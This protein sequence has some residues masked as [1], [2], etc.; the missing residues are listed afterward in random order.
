M[1]KLLASLAFLTLLGFVSC[2]EYAEDKTSREVAVTMNT[3]LNSFTGGNSV[4]FVGNTYSL[5]LCVNSKFGIG[6]YPVSMTYSCNKNLEVSE[7]PK[8]YSQNDTLGFSLAQERVLGVKVKEIGVHRLSLTFKDN[9]GAILAVEELNF[10]IAAPDLTIMIL[11]N[12]AALDKL[13]DIPHFIEQESSF[14][15]RT[16]SLKES[17]EDGKVGVTLQRVG[18]SVELKNW[19]DGETKYSTSLQTYSTRSSAKEL[20][21][22]PEYVR[23]LVRQN[24]EVSQADFVVEHKN[25]AEGETGLNLV[26]KTNNASVALTDKITVRQGS[27]GFFIN[28]A[29]YDQQSHQYSRPEH[30]VGEVDSLDY[31]IDV[32]YFNVG[33]SVFKVKFEVVGDPT[34]INLH[35]QK[36]LPVNADESNFY[37]FGQWYDFSDKLTGKIY[38]TVIGGDAHDDVVKIIVKN[39]EL[40][41]EVTAAVAVKAKQTADFKLGVQ[42][43]QLTESGDE[44]VVNDTILYSE[45]V[46][47]IQKPVVIKVQDD[48]PTSLFD[49]KLIQDN[50]NVIQNKLRHVWGDDYTIVYGS[51]AAKATQYISEQL[52]LTLVATNQNWEGYLGDFDIEYTVKRVIDGKEKTVKKHV[53]V[54]D[55]R[56][57]FQLESLV[58]TLDGFINEPVN[59][60]RVKYLEGFHYTNLEMK[61]YTDDNTVM[62][63]EF[64]TPTQ[65]F[66]RVNMGEFA[67]PPASHNGA[68]PIVNGGA[69]LRIIGAKVGTYNVHFLLRDKISGAQKTLT[70]T[71][72]VKD[73]PVQYSIVAAGSI[74]FM[75]KVREAVPLNGSH[76]VREMAR[77]RL[78]ILS[79][80]LYSGNTAAGT[81]K[82]VFIKNNNGQNNIIRLRMTDHPAGGGSAITY[83]D[84]YTLDIEKDYYLVLDTDPGNNAN[85]IGLDKQF[86]LQI[87]KAHNLDTPIESEIEEFKYKVRNYSPPSY[88]YSLGTKNR[89]LKSNNSS[90]GLQFCGDTEYTYQ[91]TTTVYNV[92]AKVTSV[93]INGA[94]GD[95][96]E[97]YWKADNATGTEEE[98]SYTAIPHPSGWDSA[99]DRTEKS[100][101]LKFHVI[102]NWGYS[103]E[104]IYTE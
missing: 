11:K 36:E 28:N 89:T 5:G 19:E 74:D 65:E 46:N 57:D 32:N 15:I 70:R 96:H 12:G 23:E 37:G 16:F 13:D 50:A 42:F 44:A 83:G 3:V 92:T 91:I 76:H 84:T 35:W 78:R 82:V 66:T 102:D 75:G 67:T 27:W 8:V 81:A 77:I 87:T 69:V 30:W 9:T 48:N 85:L 34:K 98:K 56:L 90:Q 51:Y 99:C 97:I 39:G 29:T 1:K 86:E 4:G 103:T 73:D 100:M 64:M 47:G 22:L 52:S 26:A 63:T 18:T 53:V 24:V 94:G 88:N 93:S 7:Q 95:A 43:K 41:Q 72:T 62:F 79:S 68:N 55:D 104:L 14:V 33:S 38:Y 54:V 59:M 101:I 6:G 31:T 21:K 25:V 49:Y 10:E 17:L 71:I 45:L 2:R 60:F 80:S 58:G 40:G 61:V 20:D